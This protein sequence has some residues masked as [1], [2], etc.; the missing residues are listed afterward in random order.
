GGGGGDGG[1]S[2]STPVQQP[3]ASGGTSDGSRVGVAPIV[4]PG[5]DHQSETEAANTST[6]L[7][8][9]QG[10][11]FSGVQEWLNQS[12]TDTSNVTPIP[13]PSC[14][15]VVKATPFTVTVSLSYHQGMEHSR[16]PFSFTVEVYNRRLNP[17][18]E[19]VS[20]RFK[21]QGSSAT[22]TFNVT[23]LTPTLN[24]NYLKI[25]DNGEHYTSSFGSLYPK[26]PTISP[27]SLLYQWPKHLY[28]STVTISGQIPESGRQIVLKS[29]INK[30]VFSIWDINNINDKNRAQ[31]FFSSVY[32]YSMFDL[33]ELC[34]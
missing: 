34:F 27:T 8:A 30:T 22:A 28:V 2:G 12:Q 16:L 13:P 18:K 21:I 33:R 26:A 15:D 10:W 19:L 23:G 29:S 17:P 32:G 7:G 14:E 1:G 3:P 11:D 25:Y 24:E 20:L 4:V 9:E 5:A 31:E 6:E